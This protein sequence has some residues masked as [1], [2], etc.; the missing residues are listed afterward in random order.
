MFLNAYAMDLFLRM[1]PE[2]YL[3]RLVVGGLETLETEYA[4]L[5]SGGSRKNI[6]AFHSH[7]DFEYG[8]R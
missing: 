3:K 2:L 6:A 7:D 1:A 5:Y 8:C 4:K